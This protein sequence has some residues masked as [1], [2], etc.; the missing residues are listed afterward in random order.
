MALLFWV[1]LAL[2][3]VGLAGLARCILIARGL[4]RDGIAEAEARARLQGLV[5]LNL[6]SV[7]L[8]AFGLAFLLVALIL[9]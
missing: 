1:G 6:A 4:R 5:A 3:L 2:T 9:G 8:A 7:G